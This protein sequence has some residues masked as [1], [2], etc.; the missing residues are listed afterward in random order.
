LQIVNSANLGKV[1]PVQCVVRQDSEHKLLAGVL[2]LVMRKYSWINSMLELIPKS[3]RS[4][5]GFLVIL[6][7]I[8]PE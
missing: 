3:L 2:P 4:T 5:E 6:H 7:Q 1:K 8:F